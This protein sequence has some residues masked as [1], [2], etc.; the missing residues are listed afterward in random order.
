M[1]G[2]SVLFLFSDFLAILVKLYSIF[3]E[4]GQKSVKKQKIYSTFG[5]ETI[6]L[7]VNDE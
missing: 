2:V 3:L 7:F 4:N 5:S 6:S 1:A